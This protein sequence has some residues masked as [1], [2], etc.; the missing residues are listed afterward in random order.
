M[1]SC[2]S[3]HQT[4]FEQYG[5]LKGYATIDG[6][7]Y[8]LAT[9]G[10]RDHTIGHRR[11]WR[12][13]HRYAIHFFMLENGDGITVG[14]VSIPVTFT[15]LVIGFISSA[16]G[17]ETRSIIECDLELEPLDENSQPP[18]DYAFSFWTN[19]MCGCDFTVTM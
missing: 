2:V 3:H 17:D 11:D 10:L 6:V 5:H 18:D 9:C 16:A 7:E 12:E 4:H 8:A 13:F 1:F 15:R 19:G 14:I